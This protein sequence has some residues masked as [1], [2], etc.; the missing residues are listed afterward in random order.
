MNFGIFSTFILGIY[1][2]AFLDVLDSFDTIKVCTAYDLNGKIVK[3]LTEALNNLENVKPI[4]ENFSG[5]KSEIK[6]CTNFNN[7]PNATKAYI[8]YLEA[9]LCVPISIVSIGP[10]RHQIINRN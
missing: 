9:E 8:H 10:K 1:V 2:Y 4:Y 3:N 5:W 7:L 6:D